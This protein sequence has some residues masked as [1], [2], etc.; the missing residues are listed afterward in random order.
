MQ[1]GLWTTTGQCC[2]APSSFNRLAPRTSL[3]ETFSWNKLKTQLVQHPVPADPSELRALLTHVY[4]RTRTGSR[5]MLEKRCKASVRRLKALRCRQMRVFSS[6]TDMAH[7]ANTSST[8]Q[9]PL[10][11]TRHRDRQ[12]PPSRNGPLLIVTGARGSFS[13]VKNRKLSLA[14]FFFLTGPHMVENIQAR[15]TFSYNHASSNMHFRS[16]HCVFVDPNEGPHQDFGI[17]GQTSERAPC[18]GKSGT[19]R[20]PVQSDFWTEPKGPVP[21]AHPVDV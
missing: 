14:I 10:H 6:S 3:P 7:S 5:W 17:G 20:G 9:L 11:G 2:T 15:N 19:T 4:H 1:A 16:I 12:H 18:D 13:L 8:R 21:A